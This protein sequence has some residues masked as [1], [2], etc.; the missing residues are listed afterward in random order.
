M[1]LTALTLAFRM[2]RPDATGEEVRKAV[3]LAEVTPFVSQLPGGFETIIGPEADSHMSDGQLQR[4]CLARA[5]IRNPRFLLLDEA[6]SALDA[7][8][9]ATIINTVV[10]LVRGTGLTCMS[11]T[12]KMPTTVQADKVLGLKQGKVAE[13]GPPAELL[14]NKDGVHAKLMNTA[15]ASSSRADAGKKDRVRR[16]RETTSNALGRPLPLPPPPSQSTSLPSPHI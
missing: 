13:F 3:D 2:G 15:A 16:I 11:I 12:H 7:R 1:L 10:R 5:L 14:R 9:E 8:T 4:I 6:T